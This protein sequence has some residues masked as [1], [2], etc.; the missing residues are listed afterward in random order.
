MKR[1]LARHV[2]GVALYQQIY[3]GMLIHVVEVP[4][5]A[6][7]RTFAAIEEPAARAYFA[8]SVQ[9]VD[10]KNPSSAELQ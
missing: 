4:P 3:G 10:S 1:F 8:D 5:P 2:S 6:R 9:N 7:N